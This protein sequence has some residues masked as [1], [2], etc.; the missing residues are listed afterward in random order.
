[1]PFRVSLRASQ[2]MSQ[3]VFR[4]LGWRESK[5]AR[6]DI[7]RENITMRQFS[8]NKIRNI[9]DRSFGWLAGPWHMHACLPCPQ[10][11]TCAV[12]GNYLSLGHVKFVLDFVSKC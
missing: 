6:C 9:C 3:C 7:S 5:R 12:L 8:H 10:F 1:M 4:S 2:M 11:Q